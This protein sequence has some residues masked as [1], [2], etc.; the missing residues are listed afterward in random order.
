[1]N[2]LVRLVRGRRRE[3]CLV[4]GLVVLSLILM[5]V[6]IRHK[7]LVSP[8]KK[9]AISIVGPL[10]SV[11][12]D[13]VDKIR[14]VQFNFR[15]ADW[16][17]SEIAHRNK[18]IEKLKGFRIAYEEL[19]RENGRLRNLTKFVNPK[20][21]KPYT[22]LV[23]ARDTTNW[24]KIITIDMG[25]KHGI[26]EETP[27]LNADGIVGHVIQIAPDRSQVLLITDA[28]GAVDAL[29]QRTRASGVFVGL[30]N[31]HST[32]WLRYVPRDEDVR[33]NARIVS[34]GY[35]GIYTKGQ[36]VGIVKSVD[37]SG[38]NLFQTIYVEPAVDFSRLEEV[39]V[40]LE[41]PIS[42]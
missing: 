7:G 30:S 38:Q 2:Q 20:S 29:V 4:G 12:Q 37:R 8:F 22:A 23:I 14:R 15:S 35:G 34:S 17:K 32:G 25:S 27:V 33:V 42:P 41:Q 18:E 3:Y 1:M 11:A 9:L 40:L 13:A 16:Y 36:L 6:Q 10:Q 5:T 24:S 19:R 26:R 39:L 31:G 28:R 21:H